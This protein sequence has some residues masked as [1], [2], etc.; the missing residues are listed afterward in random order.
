MLL[1]GVGH[2]PCGLHC[3]FELRLRDAEMRDP[4]LHTGFVGKIDGVVA[5]F[6]A[7]HCAR[8]AWPGLSDDGYFSNCSSTNITIA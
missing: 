7:V 1:N 4:S 2:G 6:H 5:G 8:S 3:V